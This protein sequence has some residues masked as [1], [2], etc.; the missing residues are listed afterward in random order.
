MFAATL[1]DC[2]HESLPFPRF[3]PQTASNRFTT[4]QAHVAVLI[5]GQGKIKA[6][7]ENDACNAQNKMM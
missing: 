4:M 2:E 7:I 5:H 6:S 3:F 1:P